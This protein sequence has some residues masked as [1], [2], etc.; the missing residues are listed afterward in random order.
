M[1]AGCQASGDV[2]I[3]N[4]EDRQELARYTFEK[5]ALRTYYN[6]QA[7]ALF[8]PERDPTRFCFSPDGETFLAGCYGGILRA[9]RG[10]QELA[11]FGD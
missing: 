8:R 6:R 2:V 4:L 1:A 5:G 9:T 7:N 11:R 10:G 3:W